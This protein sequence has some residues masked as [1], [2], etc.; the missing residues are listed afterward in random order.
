METAA[1]AWRSREALALGQVDEFS[2]RL[3]DFVGLLRRES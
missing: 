2:F 1:K 3:L